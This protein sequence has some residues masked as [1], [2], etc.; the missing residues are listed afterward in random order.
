[1]AWE[2]RERGG[3]YY[4]RSRRIGGRVVREYVGRGPLAEAAAREDAVRAAK[5][6]AQR[7]EWRARR[8]EIEAVDAQLAQLDALCRMLVR[9]ELE[10]AG[11]HQHHRGEWRKRREEKAD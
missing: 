8:E 2:R 11:F 3:I 6:E 7:R 10:A 5:R 4:T 1:M 9:T